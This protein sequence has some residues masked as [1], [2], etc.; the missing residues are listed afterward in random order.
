ME[1]HPPDHPLHTWRDF[2]IH[3]ATIVV[4]LLI[5]IGLEQTVEWFHHR[6]VVHVAR[7]NIHRELESNEREASKDI[8]Y[9][10]QGIQRAKDNIATLQR[11][12]QGTV[13]EHE[14]LV[15]TLSFSTLS[16]SAW[17]T[18]RDTG[19]L[20]YMP[21]DEVQSD[22]D[23]YTATAEV[24]QHASEAANDWF[25]ALAPVYENY[26]FKHIPQEEITAMLRGN[27]QARINLETET[28][29]IQQLNADMHN[30]LAE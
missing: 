2:F 27:A 19:A 7:E 10:Q 1:V 12:R 30:A 16:D 23:I 3:I 26:D 17:R 6:H 14:S 22:S 25:K 13:A 20:A 21:Y 28:Q 11:M 4:G 5:A 8:S 18:A 24:N 15:N 29:Y 9:M